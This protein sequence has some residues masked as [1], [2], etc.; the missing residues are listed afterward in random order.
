MDAKTK[1][2]LERPF[3][4]KDVDQ[5]YNNF[6]YVKPHLVVARLNEA[7]GQ[8]GWQFVPEERIEDVESITQFGKIGI[9]DETGEWVW[10]QNCGGMARRYG[11]DKPHLLENQIN[12]VTDYKGAV[13]NCFK[14]C[15]MMLGVAL[16]LY[17]DAEH[18]GGSPD[19]TK[20]PRRDQQEP[21][22]MDDVTRTEN[23]LAA[24]KKGEALLKEWG[25]KPMELREEALKGTSLGGLRDVDLE[26]YAKKLRTL[27]KVEKDKQ[28]A[29]TTSGTE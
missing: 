28:D 12:R 15:A 13:S 8:D 9:K 10:K 16:E 2:I 18:E 21:A 11:K 22:G 7:F 20:P 27:Y 6:D 24:I 4:K 5:D 3:D 19:K 29:D 1:E 23:A 26:K 14:R 17:G 25:F